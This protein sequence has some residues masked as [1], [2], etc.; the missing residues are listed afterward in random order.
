MLQYFNTIK[1]LVD[2]IAA[3]GSQIESE[4]IIH[5]ILNGLPQAYQSF[6]T[7]I[8]TMTQS[9]NL[10]QLYSLLISEE[11]HI[12]SDAARFA[13]QNQ[14]DTALFSARGR[15]R[16]GKTRPAGSRTTSSQPPTICQIC[17]KRGHT[18]A[19]CWH[20]LNAQYV[21]ASQ[22][23]TNKTLAATS[24][25]PSNEWYLDS[26]ASSHMTKSFDN[27]SVSTPYQGFDGIIIGDGSSVSIAHS[28]NGLLP[29]PSR[30]L[31]LSHI[32][33]TPQLQYNLISISQLT[34]DN[35]ISIIFD[36]NGFVL[37]DLT[38]HQILLKGPCKNGLYPL[39]T[40]AVSSSNTALLTTKQR[41][42]LW[43][44]R[45]GHPNQKVRTRIAEFHPQLG[46]NKHHVI[47]HS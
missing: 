46:I 25:Q 11:I 35:N 36:P 23:Q 41:A 13:P 8:R 9:L 15:G 20:R 18:D 16:R 47:C 26:G 19:E 10:D 30:K 5:H 43:H 32:L 24:T 1:S 7:T 31:T 3:A 38:T 2:R 37:K 6:K 45:L 4:D 21:P 28:G 27:L 12:A 17:L 14:V 34:R 22:S 33:H 42:S 29:T 39:H 40:P 44:D